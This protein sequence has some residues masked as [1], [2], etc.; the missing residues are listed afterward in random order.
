MTLDDET[1]E[2]DVFAHKTDEFV[3][4]WLEN[5][6]PKLKHPGFGNTHDMVQSA[7]RRLRAGYAARDAEVEE[8]RAEL[9]ILRATED[10]NL[11]AMRERAEKAEATLAKVQ[12][13]IGPAE[14]GPWHSTYR[15]DILAILDE[16]PTE[17]ETPADREDVARVLRDADRPDVPAHLP[18]SRSYARMAAALMERF[19]ITD[20]AHS[21]S[22]ALTSPEVM[23]SDAVSGETPAGEWEYQYIPV[24]EDG[25]E[26]AGRSREE[27]DELIRAHA[28]PNHWIHEPHNDDLYPVVS[29]RVE[30]RRKAGPWEAVPD[31]RA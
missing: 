20:G 1:A 7:I 4:Q 3:A 8:L 11:S 9:D 6:L 10:G 21:S 29:Y 26:W 16:S 13:Y 23:T 15:F 28:D 30:R 14:N 19:T 22:V 12:E 31:D 27:C 18:P 25:E 17:R 5:D 2:R 24:T